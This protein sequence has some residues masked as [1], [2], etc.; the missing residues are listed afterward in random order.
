MA[1]YLTSRQIRKIEAGLPAA[2]QVRKVI[3]IIK[4]TSEITSLYLGVPVSKGVQV[5]SQM[6]GIRASLTYKRYIFLII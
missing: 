3:P 1:G 5:L 4:I 2:Q 6:L